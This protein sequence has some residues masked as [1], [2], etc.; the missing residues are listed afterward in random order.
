MK[1]AIRTIAVVLS[2]GLLPGCGYDASYVQINGG[3][4]TTSDVNLTLAIHAKNDKGVYS[5]FITQ[6]DAAVTPATPA[7]ND[8]S[9]QSTGAGTV[10]DAE[11][12]LVLQ[13]PDMQGMR[14]VYVWFKD[15]YGSVSDPVSDTI[16]YATT[17]APVAPGYP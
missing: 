11:R 15:G 5:Y 1:T 10:W 7:A 8:A 3:E 14:S 16:D 9:W 17:A 2:F 6:C 13:N 4:A 12:T